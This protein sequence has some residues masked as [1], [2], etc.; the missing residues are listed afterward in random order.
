MRRGVPVPTAPPLRMPVI[1]PNFPTSVHR[2]DGTSGCVIE[3]IEGFHAEPQPEP[4]CYRELFLKRRVDLIVAGT[5][6]DVAAQVAVQAGRREGEGVGIFAAGLKP[7]KENI[8]LHE[9]SGDQ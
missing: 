9:G 6:C 1:C 7:R 8:V 2:F 4:L 5:K 3:E